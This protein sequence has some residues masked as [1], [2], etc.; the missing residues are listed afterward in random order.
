MAGVV[1]VGTGAV[2]AAPSV[3]SYPTMRALHDWWRTQ[4]Y[5]HQAC[6][7]YCYRP[8]WYGYSRVCEE[9]DFRGMP[10]GP[11]HV[12]RVSCRELDGLFVTAEAGMRGQRKIDFW[13]AF[14]HLG[15]RVQ[16]KGTCCAG[17]Y[18]IADGSHGRSFELMVGD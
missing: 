18:L 6:S 13:P 10:L 16:D 12:R 11:V 1:A 8:S 14:Q 3:L 4:T 2:V 9:P 17:D 5:D 7:P 15:F